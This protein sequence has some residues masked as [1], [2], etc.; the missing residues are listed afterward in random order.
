ML[1]RMATSLTVDEHGDGIGNAWTVLRENARLAGLATPVPTCP[2]WTVEELVLH[3]GLVHRWANRILRG[4]PV[5]EAGTIDLPVSDEV[6]AREGF[7]ASDPFDWLDVGAR[8]LLQTLAFAPDDLDV[9]FFLRDAHPPRFAWARRQCHETT[10][11]AVDA[12]TARLGRA[13]TADE[14]WFSDR[15]AADGVDELLTGFVPRRSQRLRSTSPY[16]VLVETSD[17]GHRWLLEVSEEPVVTTA[18]MASDD[19]PPFD[20]RLAAD[21]VP[22]FLHLW[23]RTP[24]DVDLECSDPP[25]IAQ[26]RE[27]LQIV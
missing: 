26:W 20:A 24:T 1:G 18:L 8:A 3:L 5:D 4:V 15:L 6:R 10:V 16:S 7:T 19:R 27:Q 14:V 9:F 11:H 17:T 21:A 13:P 25:V 12:M 23:N 2:G 22:L